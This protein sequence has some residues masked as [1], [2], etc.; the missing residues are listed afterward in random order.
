MHYLIDFHLD[1]FLRFLHRVAGGQPWRQAWADERLPRFSDLDDALVDYQ[2]RGRYGLWQVRAEGPSEREYALE[3]VPL[4]DALALRSLLLWIATGRP[5]RSDAA[6]AAAADLRRAL[7]IDPSGQRAR[8]LAAALG[9]LNPPA[10]SDH[11]QQ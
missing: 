1:P 9:S 5:E 10:E 2:R 7:D 11:G 6:G 3:P 8:R 4:S